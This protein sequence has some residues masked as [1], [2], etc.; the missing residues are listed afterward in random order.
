MFLLQHEKMCVFA[1]SD[2]IESIAAGMAATH[3]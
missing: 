1:L 3:C 2:K